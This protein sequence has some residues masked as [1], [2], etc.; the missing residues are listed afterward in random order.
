MSTRMAEMMAYTAEELQA[1]LDDPKSE[2][3][4][5][6]A[7]KAIKRAMR[8][9]DAHADMSLLMDR[10]E[11]KVAQELNVRAQAAPSLTDAQLAGIA[12]GTLD[13]ATLVDL[14]PR[15]LPPPASGDDW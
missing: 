7:A 3:R 15:V 4:D 12:A 10:T 13:P 1:V 11:G 5:L 8:A 14:G 6:L 9:E 2:I